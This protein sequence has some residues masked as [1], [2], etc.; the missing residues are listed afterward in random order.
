MRKLAK[1]SSYFLLILSYKNLSHYFI[2]IPLSFSFRMSFRFYSI[3][4]NK[5][6]VVSV[7]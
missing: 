7:A 4:V 2:S 6:G 3:L 1:K 5:G